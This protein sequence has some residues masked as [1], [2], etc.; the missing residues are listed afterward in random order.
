MTVKEL[1]DFLNE[2]IEEFPDV[3][4]SEVRVECW[5]TDEPWNDEYRVFEPVQNVEYLTDKKIL[6][7]EPED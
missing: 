2:L 4:D 1:K 3:R 7:V 5:E 6:V